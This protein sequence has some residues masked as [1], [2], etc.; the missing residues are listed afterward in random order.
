LPPP[1][2]GAVE[3]LESASITAAVM[4]GTYNQPVFLKRR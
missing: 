2:N 4:A 1:G 3:S